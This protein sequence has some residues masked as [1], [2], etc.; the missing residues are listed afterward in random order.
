MRHDPFGGWFFRGGGADIGVEVEP[1]HPPETDAQILQQP[2]SNETQLNVPFIRPELSAD[3]L[4][5]E[6]GFALHILFATAAVNGSH[7]CHPKVISISPYSVNGL[8]K[9]DFDLKSPAIKTDDF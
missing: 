6:F 9:A 7:V 3:V 8:L 5:I 1:S 2:L 4:T